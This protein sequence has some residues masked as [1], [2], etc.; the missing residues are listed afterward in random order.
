MFAENYD[1]TNLI[2][3]IEEHLARVRDP[4]S[5][6]LPVNNCSIFMNYFLSSLK[7]QI[8]DIDAAT[9]YAEDALKEVKEYYGH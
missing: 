5:R 7:M 1:R 6:L 9:R 8:G 4:A 3:E 2:S